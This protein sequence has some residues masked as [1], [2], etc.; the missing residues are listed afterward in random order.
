MP[1]FQPSPM[2]VIRNQLL[3][4]MVLHLLG[5]CSPILKTPTI[6]A[7]IEKSCSSNVQTMQQCRALSNDHVTNQFLRQPNLNLINHVKHI[8]PSYI[9]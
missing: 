9:C 2:V 5:S 6:A 3:A 1:Q 7:K 8:P 4:F